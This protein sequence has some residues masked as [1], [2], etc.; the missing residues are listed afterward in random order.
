MILGIQ[1]KCGKAL[2]CRSGQAM[3]EY[4]VVAGILLA[5]TAIMTLFLSVFRDYGTRV[6][7]LVG[8]EYP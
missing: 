4:V 5:S 3:V 1:S 2:R 8:S 7:N 6:L